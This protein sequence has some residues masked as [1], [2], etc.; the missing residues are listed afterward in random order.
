MSGIDAASSQTQ[1]ASN[2][3][4]PACTTSD[5]LVNSNADVPL[6]GKKVLTYDKAHAYTMKVLR[7]GFVIQT[8]EQI[9]AISQLK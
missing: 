4:E 1:S 7:Q 9:L 6:L 2:K 3:T 8:N 5:S